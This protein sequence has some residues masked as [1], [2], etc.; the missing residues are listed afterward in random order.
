VRRHGAGAPAWHR[1]PGAQRLLAWCGAP[2]GY[3]RSHRQ[4]VSCCQRA[5]VL[6]PRV[7]LVCQY[8]P[9]GAIRPDLLRYLHALRDCGFSVV[10]V[11]NSGA[12]RPAADAAAREA[13]AAV[14]VR[15]NTGRDFCAWRDA[16]ER[17]GL[18]RAE[19]EAVMLANDSVYGPLQPLAPLLQRMDG[20]GLW[21]MTAN[22]Q[23][24]WH[25]QSYFLLAGGDVL[26]SAAWRRF[27]RGVRPL[28]SK[29][30]TVG[31]YEVGLTRTLSRAG[32]RCRALFGPGDGNPMLQDWRA[33]LAAGLPFVK[34]ELLRDNP[35]RV[36]D[37]ADWAEVVERIAGAE[38][39]R[40]ILAD[41][42][43]GNSPSTCRKE[44]GRCATDIAVSERNSPSPCGRRM[45]GGVE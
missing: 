6:G 37:A 9:R 17:L 10:L 45:G 18:P 23:R 38:A 42:A 35:T 13:C 41:I 7:A 25:L 28:P 19:T 8:D 15:R 32:F 26:R 11:S 39:V 24:G 20:A 44:T 30:L 4:T 34:R 43:A 3:L 5:A 14:L 29:W 22:A 33:L 36:G 16:M 21:G 12:L 2:L 31:R 40:E 1:I 27:W